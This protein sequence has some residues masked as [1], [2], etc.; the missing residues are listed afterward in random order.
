LKNKVT[1]IDLVL[2]AKDYFIDYLSG[3]ITC[4]SLPEPGSYIRYKYTEDEL[5]LKSSPVVI[6]NIQSQDLKEKMFEQVAQPNSE[7]S[8]SGKV[9]HFGADIINELLSVKS[10]T[11]KE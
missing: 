7:P 10:L 2:E 3:K 9:T 1:T 11:Y 4:S 6:G 8:V 5:I